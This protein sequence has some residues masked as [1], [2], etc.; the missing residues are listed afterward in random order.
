MLGA[1]MGGDGRGQQGT[2]RGTAHSAVRDSLDS[3][4]PAVEEVAKG[5]KET[6]GGRHK[7]APVLISYAVKAHVTYQR[8][9]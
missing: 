7:A 5:T 4:V 2:D 3:L 9:V 1:E 6:T 8:R